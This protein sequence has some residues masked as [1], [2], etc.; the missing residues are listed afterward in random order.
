MYPYIYKNIKTG[1]KVY[2]FIELKD[3][4]LELTFSIKKVVIDA[5]IE[6]KEVEIKKDKKYD[7]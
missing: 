7:K 6:T 2:S 1:G 5:P 4:D 3:E